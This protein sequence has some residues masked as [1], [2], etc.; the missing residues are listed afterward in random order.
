MNYRLKFNELVKRIIN[1]G[2]YV[3]AT[4]YDRSKLP[5]LIASYQTDEAMVMCLSNHSIQVSR[6][7]T[8]GH[9]P[10]SLYLTLTLLLRSISPKVI[11][12]SSS[13]YAMKPSHLHRIK[14]AVKISKQ[15]HLIRWQRVDFVH[16]T[17]PCWNISPKRS[18]NCWHCWKLVNAD[19][20]TFCRFTICKNWPYSYLVQ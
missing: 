4:P 16:R 15:S 1:N 5:H 7:L 20:A 6:L 3:V 17:W 14:C 10:P 8:L 11:K 18:N 19:T 9:W 2:R 12:R 13:I